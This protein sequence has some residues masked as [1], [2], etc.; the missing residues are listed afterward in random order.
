MVAATG[1]PTGRPTAAAADRPTADRRGTRR[2]PLIARL[3]A[4]FRTRLG[5][6]LL[7]L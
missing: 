5:R 3:P 4:V 1:R 7:C 6:S 2:A